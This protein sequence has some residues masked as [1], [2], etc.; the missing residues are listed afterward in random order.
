MV[1]DGRNKLLMIMLWNLQY[2]LQ[3]QN[4]VFLM[5]EN[6]ASQVM[7]VLNLIIEKVKYSN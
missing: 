5:L 1:F 4:H 3:V 2:F 7:A 6:G